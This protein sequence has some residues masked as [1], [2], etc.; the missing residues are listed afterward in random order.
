VTA[1]RRIDVHALD[2]ADRRSQRMEGD[3]TGRRTIVTRD[4]EPATWRL[5]RRGKRSQ[6]R[7][8]RRRIVGGRVGRDVRLNQGARIGKCRKIR[9]GNDLDQW[10]TYRSDEE[11]LCQPHKNLKSKSKS[12]LTLDAGGVF[13]ILLHGP[14]GMRML[15]MTTNRIVFAGVQPHPNTVNTTVN[16]DPFNPLWGKRAVTFGARQS[17]RALPRRGSRNTGCWR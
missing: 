1:V 8:P 14:N 7:R 16:L 17:V 13:G 4:P 6:K 5:V 2:L 15:D 3:T 10:A 12:A 9:G 11:N